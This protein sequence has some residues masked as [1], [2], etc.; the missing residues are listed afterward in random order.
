MIILDI[1]DKISEICG[2]GELEQTMYVSAIEEGLT[3]PIEKI[4]FRELNFDWE[5]DLAE[6][7]NLLSHLGYEFSSI[8]HDVLE[9]LCDK[10]LIE[11][12][13]R[14]AEELE[15]VDVDKLEFVLNYN[16]DTLGIEE[17]LA[18]VE[19]V[20]V[21]R[22]IADCGEEIAALHYPACEKS[23]LWNHINFEEYGEDILQD[24]YYEEKEDG[25]I[26]VL[27]E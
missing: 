11:D 17:L 4:R 22:S 26:L 21:Y 15:V 24:A 23:Q 18:K 13:I 8:G 20:C 16:A 25:S 27:W 12:V 7:V 5:N 14:N 2:M 19:E 6:L 1:T 9:L 10:Y 3:E